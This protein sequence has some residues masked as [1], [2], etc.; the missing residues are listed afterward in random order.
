MAD[1]VCDGSIY[2]RAARVKGSSLFPLFRSLLRGCCRFSLFS[3]HR[4]RFVRSRPAHCLLQSLMAIAP[5]LMMMLPFR[6]IADLVGSRYRAG[7]VF[8]FLFWP[9]LFLVGRY[10]AHFVAAETSQ[11]DSFLVFLPPSAVEGRVR[12]PKRKANKEKHGNG[13]HQG[14]RNGQRTTKK[15]NSFRWTPFEA[16]K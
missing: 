15:R 12:R 1:V 6:F 2:P 7:V 13:G 3:F 9:F 14:G 16:R 8:S 10:P 4:R 11:S 5:L